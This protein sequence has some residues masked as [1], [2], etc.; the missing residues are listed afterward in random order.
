MEKLF[1]FLIFIVLSG[2]STNGF[3]QNSY[4][5]FDVTGKPISAKGMILKKGDLITAE[6][7]FTVKT[8]QKV[9]LTDNEGQLFEIPE[10]N[11]CD[12]LKVPS[13]KKNMETG[14]FS[15]KYLAYVW[16]KFSKQESGNA[17]IGAVYRNDKNYKQL[18]PLDSVKLYVP[19]IDFAWVTEK[20]DDKSYFFLQEEGQ[21]HI[22]KIGVDGNN[23]HLFVD[24]QLL[25]PG[26]TYFWGAS[27]EKFPDTD[28]MK[29]A[30]FTLLD[31]KEF[32]TMASQI[33]ELRTDMS[34]LG[35][36]EVEIKE[37]LC[38][39]YKLCY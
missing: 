18:A 17:N 14:S 37:M 12:F 13:F 11:N 9:L 32:D 36:T 26:K 33:N 31:K 22:T 35:F 23:L 34:Q 39:D 30:S 7:A 20:P 4:C 25:K 29:L 1:T 15:K 8:G 16:K 21:D 27:R 5:V 3:A 28:A 19:E 24:Y 2:V 10:N 6:D 38:K